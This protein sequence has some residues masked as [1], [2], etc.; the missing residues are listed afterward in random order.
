M[1]KKI[2]LKTIKI[3]FLQCV[4]LII[5]IT[6]VGA[7][8]N[9]HN[10]Y[11]NGNAVAVDSGVN[12]TNS[13]QQTQNGNAADL[14]SGTNNASQE[15]T[16][17][18]AGSASQVSKLN[19]DYEYSY[20]GF[21]PKIINIADDTPFSQIL[22]NGNNVLPEDYKPT[23]AEAVAGSGVYLDY[24]VAPF[25]QAMYDAALEYGITLTPVSGYRSYELQKKNFEN[26]IDELTDDET[27]KT[28]ATIEAAT[29]IMIPGG[30]EHNA[31]IAMDI[32]SISES[33]EDTDE[34]AWLNEHA[35]DYG[36]ILRYP[37]DE[38]ARAITK[39]IYEPWHYRFVG[40]EAAKDITS[41]GIT[42]E[43]YL[44]EN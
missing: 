21:T 44:D 25:Y 8:I 15:V 2:T 43:E 30:S 32:G 35:A 42:L 9:V 41:R 10:E 17:G 1:N 33:F 24:R 28:Q 26:L 18:D 4:L 14:T 37:K 40:V 20:A 27:D 39:V 22:L 12:V 29:R 31:G 13:N 23:L 34:F 3:I 36:F 19:T 6:V 16:K 11:K 38:S 7:A 5:A